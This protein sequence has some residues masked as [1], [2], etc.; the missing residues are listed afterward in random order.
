[1]ATIS[2]LVEINLPLVFT[3]DE[4]SANVS[5]TPLIH[6]SF[7]EADHPTV[8]VPV[9]EPEPHAIPISNITREYHWTPIDLAKQTS[10]AELYRTLYPELQCVLFQ[11]WQAPPV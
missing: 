3:T 4:A 7:C 2:S 10:S 11:S 5:K 9:W 1:M 6:W 8:I